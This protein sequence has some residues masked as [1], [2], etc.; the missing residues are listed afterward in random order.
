MMLR[1]YIRYFEKK[2]EFTEQHKE[3]CTHETI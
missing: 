3:L 2:D 1:T